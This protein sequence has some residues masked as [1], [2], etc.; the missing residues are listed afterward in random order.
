MI[1]PWECPNFGKWEQ[2]REIN[3]LVNFEIFLYDASYIERPY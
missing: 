3:L 2:W 1:I